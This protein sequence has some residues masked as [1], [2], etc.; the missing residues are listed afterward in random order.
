VDRSVYARAADGIKR[1]RHLGRFG[2]FVRDGGFGRAARP[3]PN[4]RYVTFESFALTPSGG[5][6]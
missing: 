5:R 3:G 1:L 6:R 2:A 4:V